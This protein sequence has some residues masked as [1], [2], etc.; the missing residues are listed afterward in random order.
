MNAKEQLEASIHKRAR[1]YVL[2]CLNFYPG[3]PTNA[4]VVADFV[5]TCGLSVS[6]SEVIQQLNY[7]K[8]KGYVEVTEVSDTR[9]GGE[10]ILSAQISPK[11]ID[12]LE[13][14]IE[15]DAGIILPNTR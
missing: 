4:M 8:S 14:S 15:E 7:L 12:L 13:A 2:K 11:G 1:G 10:R 5:R 3:E 6:D 9:L